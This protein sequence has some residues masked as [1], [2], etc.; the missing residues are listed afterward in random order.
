MKKLDVVIN[1][2]PRSTVL[3]KR[4]A[5]KT[6]YHNDVI[7]PKE[8][9]KTLAYTKHQDTGYRYEKDTTR[10]LFELL[11]KG[12]GQK[13]YDYYGQFLSFPEFLLYIFHLC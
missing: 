6:I 9:A 11:T 3:S 12:S 2:K 7:C 8:K 4:R 5:L 13:G 1:P 10:N